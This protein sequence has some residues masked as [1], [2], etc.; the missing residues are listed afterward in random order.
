MSESGNIFRDLLFRP[1]GQPKFEQ[2]P[3]FPGRLATADIY[4]GAKVILYCK[5]CLPVKVIVLAVATDNFTY[6]TPALDQDFTQSKADHGLEPYDNGTWNKT[7]Y[8]GRWIA[9]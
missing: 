6:Y 8:V 9:E 7:N 1:G 5:D 4:P 3:P 2:P